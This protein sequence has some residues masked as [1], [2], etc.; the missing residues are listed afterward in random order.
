ME[1][2]IE[3]KKKSVANLT[4]GVHHLP[5]RIKYDGPSSVSHYFN[6][7][8][9]D[10]EVEGL[11]V[12]EA[13]FR[14]RKLLGA[15]LPMPQGYSGFVLGKKSLG[16][17]KA[18]DVSE[19]VGNIWEM[20]AK[21]GNITYWNHDTLPSQNDS[22]LRSLHWL[23]VADAVSFCLIQQNKFKPKWSILH[24]ISLFM[25]LMGMQEIVFPPR[26]LKIVWG[27]DRNSWIIPENGDPAELVGVSWLEVT[28]SKLLEVGKYDISFK[29]SLNEKATGWDDYPIFMMARVG[30]RGRYTWRKVSL[31]KEGTK[32]IPADSEKLEIEVKPDSVDK[33]LYFG[34]YEVW[35]GK[36]KRGLIIHEAVVKKI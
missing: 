31:P 25:F 5:C 16:V 28:G 6:P 4:G 24:L 9:T 32:S 12:E 22:I 1:G 33:T 23:A 17:K 20:N 7:K 18:S 34:L 21:F 10:V 15:T 13:H 2:S 29:I 8:P 19:G 26:A 14:G 36:M 27:K 11:K 30:G 3:M 35:S